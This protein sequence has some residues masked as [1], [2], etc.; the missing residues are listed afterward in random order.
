MIIPLEIGVLD[1]PPLTRDLALLEILTMRAYGDTWAYAEL[2]ERQ[3]HRHHNR[4][5]MLYGEQLIAIARVGAY[6][7]SCY[8]RS[9]VRQWEKVRK[10]FEA[11]YTTHWDAWLLVGSQIMHVRGHTSQL[12]PDTLWYKPDGVLRLYYVQKP[13]WSLDRA[14][15]VPL[16][17][18]GPR[19]Q[20]YQRDLQDCLERAENLKQNIS[21]MVAEEP[22]PAPAEPAPP[23]SLFEHLKGSSETP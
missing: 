9:V 17:P 20:D 16:L 6:N 19:L 1:P 12:F 7:Q 5:E 18:R 2:V 15:L 14:E 4:R 8:S 10:V 13:R 21:R 22:R 23:V 3:T 11:R